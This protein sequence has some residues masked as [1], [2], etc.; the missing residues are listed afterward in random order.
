[1]NSVLIKFPKLF[2]SFFGSSLYPEKIK[3]WLSDIDLFVV[4]EGTI[5][6]FEVAKAIWEVK[7]K[8]EAVNTYTSNINYNRAIKEW[9]LL[10]RL[11]I[12]HYGSVEMMW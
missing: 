8:I 11:L 4:S 10:S 2:W 12:Y 6:P 9:F 3:I 7:Q 1:L 5:F